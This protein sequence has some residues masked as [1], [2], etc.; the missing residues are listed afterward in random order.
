ME[1][2]QCCL[3]PQRKGSSQ[4]PLIRIGDFRTLKL[5]K[6]SHIHTDDQELIVVL[7]AQIAAAKNGNHDLFHLVTHGSQSDE[8]YNAKIHKCS[9]LRGKAQ[10]KQVCGE[11]CD[12][13]LQIERRKTKER[14]FFCSPIHLIRWLW[15]FKTSGAADKLDKPE[16]KKTKSKKTAP[17]TKKKSSPKKKKHVEPEED[18]IEEVEEEEEE[19]E[20]EE[21]EELEEEVEE[22]DLGMQN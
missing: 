19:E 3:C 12:S 20:E 9:G 4:L 1:G 14:L 11:T 18:Q 16:K 2:S 7:N 5:C 17:K 6:K 8:D 13:W 21:D 10:K 22:S 15:V